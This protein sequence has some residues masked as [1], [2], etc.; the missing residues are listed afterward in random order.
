MKFSKRLAISL[1]ALLIVSLS[2]CQCWIEEF[3]V[4]AIGTT[5]RI[6]NGGIIT[7]RV[8][9]LSTFGSYGNGCPPSSTT[10]T[11]VEFYNGANKL[12]SGTKSVNTFRFD[13]NITPGKDGIAATGISEVVLTAVDQTGTRSTGL[14]NFSVQAP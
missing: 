6:D 8:I 3:R 4:F 13:W 11:S 1:A 12:G 14:L 5:G 9:E 10:I 2:G 7:P